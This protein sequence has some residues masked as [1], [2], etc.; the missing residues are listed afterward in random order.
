MKE[1]D[2]L[3]Q[4]AEDM[5]YRI[6]RAVA[7]A[8]ELT[9][10]HDPD[11]REKYVKALHKAVDEGEVSAE[12]P[13]DVKAKA[14]KLIDQGNYEEALVKCLK[15]RRL[16]RKENPYDHEDY[17]SAFMF[18]ELGNCFLHHKLQFSLF[19]YSAEYA[20]RKDLGTSPQFNTVNRWS[21]YIECIYK[22]AVLK[23]MEGEFQ[24]AL[25]LIEELFGWC[26]DERIGE[27]EE[28]LFLQFLG[29]SYSIQEHHLSF[30]KVLYI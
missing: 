15:Y 18:H 26:R 3:L 9:C 12:K 27:G 20:I 6:T 25:D 21:C 22:M 4:E 14:S 10:F 2:P 11:A 19:F 23:N 5:I 29:S 30:E 16:L 24:L 1:R 17:L 13:K 7:S 8:D 28:Y